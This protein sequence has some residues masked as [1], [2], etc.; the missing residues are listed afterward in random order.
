MAQF[1]KFSFVLDINPPSLVWHGVHDAVTILFTS[2]GSVAFVSEVSC[3]FAR[4]LRKNRLKIKTTG[5][6]DDDFAY[7][8]IISDIRL[9]IL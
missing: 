3:M 7:S 9:L 6:N 8:F 4:K 5:T 2:A 1:V